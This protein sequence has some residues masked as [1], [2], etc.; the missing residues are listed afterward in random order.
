LRDVSLLPSRLAL[1]ATIDKTL[2]DDIFTFSLAEVR[3][4]S[5]AGNNTTKNFEQ[6]AEGLNQEEKKISC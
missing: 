2:F 5:P 3:A 4:K 1:H 6:M